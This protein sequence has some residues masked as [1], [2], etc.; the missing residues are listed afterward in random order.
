[1]ATIEQN[2]QV[3]DRDWPDE[4]QGWSVA[5][6]GVES[7]WFGTILPRIQAFIPTDTI[8]EIAPGFGRWTQYLIDHCHD[9]I[10]VDL[11]EKCIKACENRF[12]AYSHVKC[13]INDG[14][15]LD[16]IQDRSIGFAFSFDS[17]V[18]ADND[19]IEA[20]L[21]QLAIKLTPNG[22]G[23]IHHSNIGA[24]VNGSMGVQTSDLSNAHWRAENMTARLFQEYCEK[25]GLQCITQEIINWGGE[26]LNDCFSLFTCKGSV[27]SRPN[28][29]ITNASFMDEVKHF[30]RMSQLYATSSFKK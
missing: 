27:W 16:M 10:V 25:T 6:G 19:V 29:V 26:V 23:F 4:G 22:V 13:H 24:Y 2:K 9:L 18:H 21:K 1:M 30:S 3:W 17:L 15:S 7:Q 12:Q 20:Y 14:K 11:A 5:W 8:L 28:K